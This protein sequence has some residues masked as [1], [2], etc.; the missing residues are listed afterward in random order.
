MA[1]KAYIDINTIPYDAPLSIE[2]PTKEW[3]SEQS[4]KGLTRETLSVPDVDLTGKW[5]IVTGANSGIGREA[6]LQFAKWGASIVLACRNP[7]AHEPRPEK[8]GEECKEA[9]KSNGHLDSAFESW[10]VDY[11]DL[12]T[13]DAFADRWLA[14]GRPLDILCN[15]VGIGSSPGGASVTK[16]K[17]GFEIYHQV[18]FL[19]HVLLTLRL[20]PALAKAPTPRVVCTV[21][22]MHFFGEFD[23]R[24]CN[25][26]LNRPGFDGV[27]FYQNNKLWFQ[28]WLTELQ[29]RM[30][31][32][33]EYK[34][35]TINGVHPGYINS[36][37]WNLTYDSW[38]RPIKTAMWK[39]LAHFIAI[40]SQQGSLCIINGATAVDAGPD[41]KV[42]GVGVQGGKGGGRYYSRIKEAT[43]MPH[44]KDPDCR[45]RLWRKV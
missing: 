16:T 19:A 20:L 1:E 7:P 9:A 43:P 18:N 44:T 3:S 4:R 41:P 12:K 34:H 38:L 24:N 26:E 23:L 14:T 42:Q 15:N 21:S 11:V 32:H 45:Q 6:T 17:D 8:V 27:A 10:V 25:G 2:E 37:I 36:E 33:E 22:S 30:L 31:Q 5:I 28:I 35:I 13:V 40:S 29:R 39:L